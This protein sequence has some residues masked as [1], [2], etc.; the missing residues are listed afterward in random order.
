MTT[1]LTTNIDL[2]DFRADYEAIYKSPE[3]N[4]TALW[5]AYYKR[6]H[7][8]LLA[9]CGLEFS[10]WTPRNGQTVNFEPVMERMYIKRDG[11][12]LGFIQV[13]RSTR[14]PEGYVESHR[15]AKGERQYVV[16]FTTSGDADSFMQFVL[17]TGRIMFRLKSGEHAKLAAEISDE[18]AFTNFC[19]L[20]LA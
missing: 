5:N 13:R 6:A 3:K 7:A 14:K 15:F 17:E 2:N 18:L 20:V 8:A 11:E 4:R 1:E 19:D 16:E 9:S 10:Y 12:D